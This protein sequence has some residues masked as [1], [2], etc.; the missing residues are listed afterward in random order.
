MRLTALGR[1]G[2]Q[3]SNQTSVRLALGR[4]SSSEDEPRQTDQD[5]ERDPR[6]VQVDRLLSAD[7]AKSAAIRSIAWSTGGGCD[8]A[9]IDGGTGAAG[10]LPS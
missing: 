4:P 5:Q 7:E 10:L 9:A 2:P 3:P 1:K 8:T 6:S